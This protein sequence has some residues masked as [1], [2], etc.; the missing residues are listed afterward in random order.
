VVN[1]EFVEL[2]RSFRLGRWALFFKI[3]LPA[4]VPFILAGLRLSVGRGLTGV[5]IAEWFGATEG[6]G[7][8]IFFAGQTLNIPTLFVGVAVFAALGIVGFEILRKIE[9]YATPWRKG[10]QGT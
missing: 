6:L 7:Y 9:S 1:R 2:A 8:L 5:A 10:F 3:L 4:S